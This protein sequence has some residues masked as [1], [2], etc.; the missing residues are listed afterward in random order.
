VTVREVE[1]EGREEVKKR[2]EQRRGDAAAAVAVGG[3]QKLR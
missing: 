3:G 1:K 2:L